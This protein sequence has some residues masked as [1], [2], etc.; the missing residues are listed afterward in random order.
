M[1]PQDILKVKNIIRI[2]PDETL[3]SALSYLSSSHDAAFVFSKDKKYLG[4]INPYH[5]LI[6]ASHPWNAKAEHCLFHAPRV[7]SN[8]TIS[9]VAQLLIESRVHYLP[10]FDEQNDKFIGIVSARH[11]LALLRQ[12]NLFHLKIKEFLQLK[13]KPVLTIFENDFVSQA[14]HVF[15]TNKISKLVVINRDMKLVGVLTHYDLIRF[16][17]TPRKKEHRGERA[18]D[19]I[20]FQYH[21]VKNFTKTYVLTLTPEHFLKDAL[22][23]ILDKEIG[24]VVVVDQDKHPL[25]IITTKDFLGLIVRAERKSAIEV[26]AKNLSQ[27]SS[28]LIGGFFQQLSSWIKTI[29]NLAKARLFI[30]EEKVGEVSGGKN[31]RKVLQDIKKAK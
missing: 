1:K 19:R 6:R 5:C 7:K 13:N 11:I 2:D 14:L 9:K 17:I 16:L 12:S 29:P 10:V 22:G 8:F 21:Q 27:E 20:S 31:L 25:G 24:S 18:G 4:V 26:I 23:M 3:S 28:R 30:K 15:K